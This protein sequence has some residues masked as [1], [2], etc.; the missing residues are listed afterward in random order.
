MGVD[1]RLMDLPAPILLERIATGAMRSADLAHLVAARTEAEAGEDLAWFDADY[2][3]K[4]GAAMDAWRGRARPL[5]PL[6][7]LP[8]AISDLV[9]TARIPTRLGFS[10]HADRMPERDAA[11][12]QGLRGAG[13]LVV[14]KSAVPAFGIGPAP[15]AARLV[16]RRL[17]PA[18]VVTGEDGSALAEA[19]AA[20]VVGFTPTAGSVSLRGTFTAAPTLAATTVLTRDLV[21]AALVADALIAP[22]PD[23]AIAVPAPSAGL[24]AAAAAQP[25]VPP[26]LA[27]VPPLWWDEADADVREAVTEL[28]EALGRHTF[29]APLPDVFREAVPQAR[30]ILKAEAAKSLH[31]T[32]A[33]YGDAVPAAVAEIVAAGQ[34]VSA[35]DYLTAR[36]WQAVLTAGLGAVFDRCDAILTPVSPR[37]GA[38]GPAE[39]NL[40]GA[41]LGLPAVTLPLLGTDTGSAIGIQLVGRRGDDRRLVRTAAWLQSYVLQQGAPA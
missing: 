25:P 24:A 21:G 29:D 17:A 2:V 33:R 23:A 8:V 36:D 40:A 28:A 11:I 26:T 14:G 37:V 20:G 4:Q 7:G 27:V 9:D 19:A 18:A 39:A 12:M 6:H 13:A 31:G 3:R 5:G 16:Q 34:S 35:V 32:M 1:P 30:R 15:A 22:E 10:G 41:F 38:A